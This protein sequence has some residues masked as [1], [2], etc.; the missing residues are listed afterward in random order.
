MMY[1]SVPM[2]AGFFAV[3]LFAGA[4][5]AFI[6]DLLRVSRRILGPG[7]RV[8]NL[9]DILFLAA[10]AVIMF[11]AAYI[12]NSGEVRW[13]GFIGFGAGAVLYAVVV[14]NRFLNVSTVIIKWLVKIT[15]KIIK[16]LLFPIRLVFKIFKRPINVVIWY[17]GRGVRRAKRLVRR[18]GDRLSFR[19]KNVG[20]ML[21]K[22]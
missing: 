1:N 18:S 22:K 21:R 12:K 20:L 19:L 15:E 4:A 14:K 7:D 16:I 13:H 17:T 8:V 2:E 11:T 6:Y 3:S 5:V 10:A 9:Q